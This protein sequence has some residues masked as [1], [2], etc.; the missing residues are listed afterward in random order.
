MA[1][2]ERQ[3]EGGEPVADAPEAE[4]EGGPAESPQAAVEDRT[5]EY[6]QGLLRLKADFDNYRRRVAQDQARWGEA[7]VA[8]F[9]V[10]LL[11]VVD[12]LE[13]ALTATTDGPGV[14]QGVEL[15]LRQLHE[16]LQGAGVTVDECVGKPFDPTR[17]EAV[18]HGPADGVAEG[19]VAEEYRKGYRM[20]DQVLRAAMVKVATAAAGAEAADGVA[21]QEEEH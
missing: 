11:G 8:A 13:R 16:V 10:Q 18:A 9:V 2:E 15:T 6:R 21:R 5:E 14:R 7:A 19:M 4:S 3:P 1:D 20:R 17:H 12:N